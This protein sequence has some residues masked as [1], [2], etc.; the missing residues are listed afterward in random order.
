MGR[1]L[2]ELVKTELRQG[3]LGVPKAFQPFDA[4][5]VAMGGYFIWDGVNTRRPTSWLS[6][7]LGAIMIYIHSQRFLYA[8]QDKVG[9]NRLL[10]DLDLTTSDIC[11]P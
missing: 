1:T 2:N 11:P 3:W 5:G 6:I 8:P 9:L 4:I 10:T 7:S